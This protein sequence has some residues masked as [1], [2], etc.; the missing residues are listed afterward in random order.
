[1]K[2]SPSRLVPISRSQLVAL[3]V[4][5]L[6]TRWKGAESTAE[7]DI[8]DRKGGTDLGDLDGRGDERVASDRLGSG[9]GSA[10]EVVRY[11]ELG[12]VLTD[13]CAR[14]RKGSAKGRTSGG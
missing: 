1:M 2:W 9:S 6:E 10:A 14:V 8:A 12:V 5:R 3:P 7:V 13:G 11:E 4:L